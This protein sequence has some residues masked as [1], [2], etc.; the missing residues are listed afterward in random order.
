MNVK[1]L[2]DTLKHFHPDTPIYINGEVGW[3]PLSSD[4]V[5]F[6]NVFRIWHSDYNLRKD[7]AYEDL[8]PVP[9]DGVYVRGNG[10]PDYVR[11]TIGKESILLVG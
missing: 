5:E 2:I 8:S 10:K 6:L 11:K 9:E 7:S 1:E 3:Y 4:D